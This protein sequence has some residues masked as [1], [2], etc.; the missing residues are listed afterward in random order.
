MQYS[1]KLKIAM[2]EIK[3]VLK[4]HDIAGAVV[5][6]TPGHSEFLMKIDPSWSCAKIERGQI[7]VRNIGF[8]RAKKKKTAEDTVNMVCLMGE[9]MGRLG[10]DMLNLEEK[11]T[12]TIEIIKFDNG[13]SSHEQQ[14]N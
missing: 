1:P 3:A 11:L 10:L 4:K 8:S 7:I 5:L 9:T 12:Q 2:E 14:N 13:S 6:H